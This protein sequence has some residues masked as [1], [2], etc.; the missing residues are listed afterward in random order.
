MEIARASVLAEMASGI[1]HELNQPLGAIATFAQASERVLNR[2][3]PI[4]KPG[5]GCVSPD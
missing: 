4:G 5:V 2:S 1:A 3:D